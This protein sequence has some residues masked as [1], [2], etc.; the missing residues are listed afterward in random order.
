MSE[1]SG[2]VGDAEI[3]T[4]YA[5]V[6]RAISCWEEVEMGLAGLHSIFVGKIGDLDVIREF[7]QKNITFS[8][9]LAAV[10]ESGD[11]YFRRRCSQEN[12]GEFKAICMEADDRSEAR[13]NL[14]HGVVQPMIWL[15]DPNRPSEPIIPTTLHVVGAPWYMSGKLE[16]VGGTG[17]GS[18]EINILTAKFLVLSNRI[19]NFAARLS[20]QSCS[21]ATNR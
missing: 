20:S 3:E 9:R 7:G 8:R 11:S 21:S 18:Y 12:E 16:T 14:A 13:N 17:L 5:A 15:C 19:H 10:K 4:T 1:M 2:L 6:G